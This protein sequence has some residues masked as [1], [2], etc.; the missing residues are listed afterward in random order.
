M[1][2]WLNSDCKWKAMGVEYARNPLN[3]LKTFL[4]RDRLNLVVKSYLVFLPIEEPLLPKFIPLSLH[5]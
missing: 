4:L 1:Y 3:S 5:S 2:K